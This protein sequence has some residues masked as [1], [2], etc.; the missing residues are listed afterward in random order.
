MRQIVLY[1]MKDYVRINKAGDFD[2]DYIKNVIREI[3]QQISAHPDHD[4]L[5]D[6]RLGT[7][8]ESVYG[9]ILEILME[10]LAIIKGFP[11]KIADIVPQDK[12]QMAFS[13]ELSR[14]LQA[15][16]IQYRAFIDYEGAIDWLSEITV[17]EE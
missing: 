15:I 8:Q 11:G 16:G 4:I 10:M 9:H 13:N 1:H 6:S 7:V 14:K 5:L 17:L 12:Q 2:L 3:G